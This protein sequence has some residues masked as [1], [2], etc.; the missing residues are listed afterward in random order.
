MTRLSFVMLLLLLAPAALGQDFDVG[1]AAHDRGDYAAAL[2]EFRPLAEQGDAEAQNILGFA[3]AIGQGVPQDYV[4]AHKW[5]NL[6]ASRGADT[7]RN[8]RDIIAERITSEQI[9]EAQRQA[10]EWQPKAE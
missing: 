4:E 2:E 3:Y 9:A 10:R 7:A 5:Y 1:V 6:A 8:N